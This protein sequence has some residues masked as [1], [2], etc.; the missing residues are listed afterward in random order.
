M[1]HSSYF[2]TFLS[3]VSFS[4]LSLS[5]FTPIMLPLFSCSPQ[6]LFKSSDMSMMYCSFLGLQR[7]CLVV[8]CWRP[9][10]GKQ[11]YLSATKG[12][13][14]TGSLRISWYKVVTLLRCSLSVQHL[15]PPNPPF[16]PLC[17]LCL[18]MNECLWKCGCSIR[19]CLCMIL[20]AITFVF[21]KCFLVT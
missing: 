8:I 15:N 14:S 13:N 7:L 16:P 20:S 21:L 18:C 9:F 10:T 12:P 3:S 19:G 5:Q 6:V 11:D 17:V 4:L 1:Y 2:P